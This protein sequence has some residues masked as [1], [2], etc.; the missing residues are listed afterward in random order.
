M[1]SSVASSSAR[2]KWSKLVPEGPEQTIASP[3]AVATLGYKVVERRRF[4]GGL[5]PAACEE[6]PG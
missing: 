4:H 6:A 3:L 1:P 5:L 2:A